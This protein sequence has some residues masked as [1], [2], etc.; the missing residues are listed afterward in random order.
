M[1]TMYV[2]LAAV[3]SIDGRITCKNESDISTWA[4]NED[5]NHFRQLLQTHDAVVMGRKTYEAVRPH[6]EPNRL[7]IVMTRQPTMFDQHV[8]PNMLEFSADSP[9]DITAQL[10][11]RGCKKLLVVGGSDIYR[12]FLAARAVDEMFLTVEPVVFG[13][14]VPLLSGH[15]DAARLSLESTTLLNDLGT[16]LLRYKCL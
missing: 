9:G 12:T 15:V 2:T 7:R 10:D 6:P 11:R 1:H 8:V 13:E 5:H 4:S 3:M 14:G 16:L